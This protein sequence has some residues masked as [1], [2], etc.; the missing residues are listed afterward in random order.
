MVVAVV[1]VGIGA[2]VA[3]AACWLLLHGV[4][5]LAL[6]PVAHGSLDTVAGVPLL[7]RLLAPAVA[8]WLP[9][10]LALLSAFTLL[11]HTEDG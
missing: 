8:A 11:F 4:Q 2:G 5:H 7:R 3:G 6:G 1:L 9:P 10:I